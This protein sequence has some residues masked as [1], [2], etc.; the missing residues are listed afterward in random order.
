MRG[1][2]PLALLVA[3]SLGA[4]CTS[5]DPPPPS[6]SPSPKV[7]AAAC[8]AGSVLGCPVRAAAASIPVAGTDLVLVYRS[9]RRDAAALS[10][11]GGWF[12]A[13]YDHLDA[14]AGVVISGEG[15]ARRVEPVDGA[16]DELLVPSPDGATV[17]V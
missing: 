6:P 9:D 16:G 4:S 10:R 17:A 7:A 14:E 5:V 12:L 11:L 8:P 1:R 15:D 2:R 13:G 3:V